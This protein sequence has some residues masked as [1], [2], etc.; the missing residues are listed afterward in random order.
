MDQNSENSQQR[1]WDNK[2]HYQWTMSSSRCAL[3]ITF[4]WLWYQIAYLLNLNLNFHSKWAQWAATTSE[5]G[6]LGLVFSGLVPLGLTPLGFAPL[7]LAP[8][9]LAPPGLA[10]SGFGPSGLC[11]FVALKAIS[12][13]PQG[14]LKLLVQANK[15]LL[16]SFSSS[17]VEVAWAQKRKRR[18]LF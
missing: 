12:G 6:P 5:L 8:L 9:G 17:L 4:S 3:C 16:E 18:I 15:I 7:S 13:I 2:L 14:Q 10:P 11:T 1:P